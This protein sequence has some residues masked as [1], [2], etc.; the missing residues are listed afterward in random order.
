M[1][2]HGLQV[3]T[4]RH[5]IMVKKPVRVIF[6]LRQMTLGGMRERQEEE[7]EEEEEEEKMMGERER[8]R[9]RG[10]EGSG[11]NN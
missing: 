2:V 8:E 4:L 6:S 3:A 5:A 9:E 11:K 10:R 1:L 7:E